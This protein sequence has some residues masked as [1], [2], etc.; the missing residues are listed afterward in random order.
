MFFCFG[1]KK[2]LD[3]LE[4]EILKEEFDALPKFVVEEN[5]YRMEFFAY[6]SY[7]VSIP[8]IDESKSR[9]KL[10][11]KSVYF[12]HKKGHADLLADRLNEAYNLAMIEIYQDSFMDEGK[13]TT[14][15][16]S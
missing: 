9:H 10:A 6:D 16:E 7:T 12:F 8:M 2:R 3:S 15:K 13:N 14:E 1:L 11:Y 5:N 4:N